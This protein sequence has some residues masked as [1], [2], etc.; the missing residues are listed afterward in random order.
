MV[1]GSVGELR[2]V[3]HLST[4][5]ALNKREGIKDALVPDGTN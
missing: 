2:G 3:D 4:D 1:G 5:E